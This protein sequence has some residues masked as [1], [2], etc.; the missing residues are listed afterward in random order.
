MFINIIAILLGTFFLFMC[1]YPKKISHPIYA[2]YAINLLAVNTF[3]FFDELDSYFSLIIVL[4]V[5]FFIASIVWLRVVGG[6][7]G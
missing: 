4:Q 3:I 1:L 5:V 6:K 2:F 7:V